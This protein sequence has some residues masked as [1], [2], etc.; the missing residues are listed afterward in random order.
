M[1]GHKS[2]LITFFHEKKSTFYN[3]GFSTEIKFIAS[4]FNEFYKEHK[5][6]LKD[7]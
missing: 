7:L 3:N 4:H 5:K 2:Q 6:D 1:K